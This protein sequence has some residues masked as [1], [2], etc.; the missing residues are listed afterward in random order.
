MKDTYT[1]RATV[2]L[3][4]KQR[5]LFWETLASVGDQNAHQIVLDFIGPDG[6][7]VDLS[8]ARVTLYAVRPDGR[9][10]LNIGTVED[11][12]AVASLDDTCYAFTGRV[13]CTMVVAI[14][15]DFLSGVR[16]W[17]NVDEASTDII[18][19][20]GSEIPSLPELLAEIE[21]MRSASQSASNAATL[22]NE[23][24]Q[25]AD[26][27]ANLA[28]TAAENAQTK[29]N[30]ANTAA[31]NA[32]AAATSANAAASSANTAATT[33]DNMTVSATGLVKDATPTATISTVSG[34]KHIE[35][36][37]PNPCEVMTGATASTDGNPG[38]APKPVAGDNTKFLRGDATYV[39]V[40]DTELTA[41]EVNSCFTNAGW[42]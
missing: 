40:A 14:N 3:R 32:Q 28:N 26:T 12:C 17:I 11:N 10:V 21:V 8:S 18:V 29:A 35:F 23:K 16:L 6:R 37:I 38:I 42:D 30:L 5:E 22:A 31:T 41:S 33:I 15:G 36:G 24:A 27:K 34:H 39:S 2:D 25:L 4:Q 20:P 19:D 1:Y 13:K 7:I 9:T